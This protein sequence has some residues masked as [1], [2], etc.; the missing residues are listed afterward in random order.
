M[1]TKSWLECHPEPVSSLGS[2][3]MFFF[4]K[5]AVSK[6]WDKEPWATPGAGKGGKDP[7]PEASR[8]H[9]PGD[10]LGLVS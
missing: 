5:K 2:L 4:T 8:P 6:P 7:L 10:I 3:D 9:G 1:R